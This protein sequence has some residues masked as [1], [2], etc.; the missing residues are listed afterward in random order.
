MVKLASWFL[1]VLVAG[2]VGCDGKKGDAVK[3]AE[4]AAPVTERGFEP[5]GNQELALLDGLRVGDMVEG[6]KVE[7]IGAVGSNGAMTVRLSEAGRKLN[8]SIALKSTRPMP[9]VYTD[10]YA[11]YFDSLDASNSV[12]SQRALEVV[13]ALAKRIRRVEKDMPVPPGMSVKGDYAVPI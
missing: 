5:A 13:E 2:A 4:S 10:K 11:V 12:G 1:V 8:V 3:P 6:F 9:P 7:W